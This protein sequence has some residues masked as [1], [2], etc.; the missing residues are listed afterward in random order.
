MFGPA[1]LLKS[2]INIVAV[3]IVNMTVGI[4]NQRIAVNS[5]TKRRKQ[6]DGV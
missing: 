2:S 5:F 6:A 1:S 4:N 3:L